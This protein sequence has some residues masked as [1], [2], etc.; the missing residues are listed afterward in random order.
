MFKLAFL[1]ELRS[2]ERWLSPILFSLSLILLFWFVM[3]E[4]TEDTK[5]AF[6]LFQTVAVGFLALKLFLMRSFEQETEDNAFAVVK[7]SETRL[8]SFYIAKLLVGTLICSFIWVTSLAIGYFFFQSFQMKPLGGV[9]VLAALASA[10]GLN[11]IGILISAMTL[12]VR[13]R[14]ILFPLCFFPLT[15]PILIATYHSMYDLWVQA[16]PLETALR[17]WL[18]FLISFD[19]TFA[20]VCYVLFTELLKRE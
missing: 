1:L 12:Q 2:K 11:A 9:L 6:F 15:V 7:G 20:G 19:I 17:G 18:G 13:G 8:G 10:L 14:Q 4:P 3:P 16:L 5:Y